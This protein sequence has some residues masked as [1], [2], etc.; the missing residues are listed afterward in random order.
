SLS[1]MLANV[2]QPSLKGAGICGS[3]SIDHFGNPS[4]GFDALA[5]DIFRFAASKLFHLL[6]VCLLC[7]RAQAHGPEQ[8]IA[9]ENLHDPASGLFCCGPNDCK[10]LKRGDVSET[11]GGWLALVA[12]RN[13][14]TVVTIAASMSRPFKATVTNG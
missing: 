2:S 13:R 3:L 14:P 12:Y 7:G 10:P 6:F 11:M 1:N 9:D 8:W 5:F 4:Q